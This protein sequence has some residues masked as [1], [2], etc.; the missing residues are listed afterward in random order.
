MT[1]FNGWWFQDVYPV[2]IP[3]F[4]HGWSLRA[5][6]LPSYQ[7]PSW[8]KQQLPTTR[9]MPTPWAHGVTR[10]HHITHER[11][12]RVLKIPKMMKWHEMTLRHQEEGRRFQE[13]SFLPNCLAL[14]L[15][16]GKEGQGEN[17]THAQRHTSAMHGTGRQISW[18]F[19][20]SVS[21]EKEIPL[22]KL[23]LQEYTQ[24]YSKYISK[25][26]I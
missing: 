3:Q 4:V 12:H 26:V 20:K 14:G 15:P 5:K 24:S 25:Y 13:R 16:E 10:G 1:D 21:K 8:C 6:S 23:S 18:Y 11:S 2:T 9:H 17:K 22:L 7:R 19:G